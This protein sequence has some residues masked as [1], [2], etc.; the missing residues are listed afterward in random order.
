MRILAAILMLATLGCDNSHASVNRSA[1][2]KSI[3]GSG[4]VRGSI[5]F[6]GTAPVM[7]AITATDANPY[8]TVLDI[9]GAQPKGGSAAS[10]PL[11][12]AGGIVVV[13]LVLG[14]GLAVMRDR[15]DRSIR[16]G[17]TAGRALHAPVLAT[18]SPSQRSHGEY[19]VLEHPTTERSLGSSGSSARSA[20]GSSSSP[21]RAGTR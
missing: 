9:S 20:T 7:K 5:K 4:I 21:W 10:S 13:G 18:I 19:T 11:I 12:P 2:P 17:R 3:P 8:A 1:L 14:L 16:D 15:L 6:I